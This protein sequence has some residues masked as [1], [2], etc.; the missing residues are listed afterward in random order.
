MMAFKPYT[1]LRPLVLLQPYT[2]QKLDPA[3]SIPTL[4]S[5]VY[6]SSKF[7]AVNLQRNN[8][9]VSSSLRFALHI[10]SSMPDLP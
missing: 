6:V 8:Q 2:S 10:Y 7:W 1:Y 4:Q 9:L 5:T 3:A